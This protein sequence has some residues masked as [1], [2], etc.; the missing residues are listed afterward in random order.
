MPELSLGEIFKL[1]GGVTGGAG[2]LLALLYGL[3]ALFRAWRDPA[4]KI[5]Q[6]ESAGMKTQL[7]ELREQL[8]ALKTLVTAL[9]TE[10]EAV[11]KNRQDL[12]YQRDRAR[13]LAESLALRHAETVP[14]WEED[15]E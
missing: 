11:K 8:A 7:G 6:S 3:T 10:L 15:P 13:V 1:A 4:A 9:S 12:R 14:S 2:M 5:W